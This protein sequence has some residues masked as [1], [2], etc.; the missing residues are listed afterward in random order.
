MITSLRTIRT[1][2]WFFGQQ[3]DAAFDGVVRAEAMDKVV[4]LHRIVVVVAD[5]AAAPDAGGNG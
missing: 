5:R 3:G 1:Q 2:I 4:H